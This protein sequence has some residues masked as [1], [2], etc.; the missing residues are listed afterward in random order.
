[1][2][3]LLRSLTPSFVRRFLHRLGVFMG[4]GVV[5]DQHFLDQGKSLMLL[6]K[7]GMQPAFALDIGAY[8]GDWTVHFKSIFPQAKVLMIEPQE[9]KASILCAIAKRYQDSVLLETC[10]L[11]RTDNEIVTFYEM[12]TGSSIYA[13]TSPYARTAVSKPLRALDALLAA[14]QLPLPDFIK[15]DVQGYELEVLLGAENALSN[16]TAVLIE[17]SLLPINKGC[18]LIKDIM[19]FFDARGFALMDVTGIS[20]R[21]DGILCQMDVIFLR[22]TSPYRPAASL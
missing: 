8:H 7:L 15:I 4:D 20:R 16:A 3:L 14:Q 22:T 6:R 18:P 17:V 19:N 21:G 9:S 1:M 5:H 2:K 11:G 10:L 12:E 13:E